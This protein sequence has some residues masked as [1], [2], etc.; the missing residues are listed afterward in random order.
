MKIDLTGKTAVVTGSSA[1]LGWG[2]AKGLAAAGA[3]IVINGRKQEALSVARGRLLAAVPEAIVRTVAADLSTVTG[4]AAL[5]NAEPAC[6]ILVNNLASGWSPK[7]FFETS[8]ED[9]TASFHTSVMP[10]VR[11]SRSYVTSM[12]ERGWGR[13]VFLSSVEAINI[14]TDAL[15]YGFGK[16]AVLNLS[17]GLAKVC[18]GSGVTVN[19]VLA[20]PTMTE[21]FA[22]LISGM[23]EQTGQVF[24]EASAAAVKQRYPTSL[25]G[26]AH[27]VEEVANLVVYICSAQASAT[28]GAALRAEG[29]I[30]ESIV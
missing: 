11:L 6:D 20:G 26:R 16:A 24:D 19:A 4:C 15:D 23:V 28:T 9:W 25:N 21:G 13:V 5:V 22:A 30:V 29:G 10:G 12:M 14:T 18:R 3:T 27:S 8:D 17:R 1:G 7:S 2:C